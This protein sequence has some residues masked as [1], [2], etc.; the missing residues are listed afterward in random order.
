MSTYFFSMINWLLRRKTDDKKED[1]HLRMSGKDLSW[2]ETIL[3]KLTDSSQ[4]A[5]LVV[6]GGMG[7]ILFFNRH[8]C[9][10]WGITHLEEAIRKRELKYDEIIDNC[11]EEVKN[12]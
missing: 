6:D 10:I 9:E 3:K 4:L 1:T 2:H 5:F 8:F 11:L 12:P 7:D